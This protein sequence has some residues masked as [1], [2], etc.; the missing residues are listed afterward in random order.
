MEVTL[1]NLHC[2]PRKYALWS[3][4]EKVEGWRGEVR[5][6][7]DDKDQKHLAKLEH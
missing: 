7:G 3:V 6:K 1:V 4:D 5:G 2:H